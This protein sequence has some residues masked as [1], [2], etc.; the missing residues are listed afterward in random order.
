MG[1]RIEAWSIPPP[2]VISQVMPTL[3]TTCFGILGYH[4]V[5]Q[6]HNTQRK[7]HCHVEFD[8]TIRPHF[9]GLQ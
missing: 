1:R 7:A 5:L 8:S 3:N 6:L 4:Q 9:L 2:I